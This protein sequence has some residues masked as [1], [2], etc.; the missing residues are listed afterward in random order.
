MG[1]YPPQVPEDTV[2]SAS[3]HISALKVCVRGRGVGL[4]GCERGHEG[5]G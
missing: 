4:Y 3:G 1:I 5:I 2:L